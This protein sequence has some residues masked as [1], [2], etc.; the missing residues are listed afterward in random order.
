MRN[1]LAFVGAVQ[2]LPPFVLVYESNARISDGVQ[3]RSYASFISATSC[4]V[5][6][7]LRDARTMGRRHW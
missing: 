4:S 5:R 2:L 3:Y 1:F 6:S 7:R